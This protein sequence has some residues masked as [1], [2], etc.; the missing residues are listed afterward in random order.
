M[1]PRDQGR[2]LRQ[3]LV[4]LAFGGAIFALFVLLGLLSSDNAASK[5][6]TPN[7]S[8]R[9]SGLPVTH[10]PSPGFSLR[11]NLATLVISKIDPPPR[12]RFRLATLGDIRG[13][14]HDVSAGAA[15]RSSTNASRL[16]SG[17]K[18]NRAS[19]LCRRP[20][21]AL[22]NNT[23]G[24]RYCV[25]QAFLL[26]PG[27]GDHARAGEVGHVEPQGPQ[28]AKYSRSLSEPL[29]SGSGRESRSSVPGKA[30]NTRRK[31]VFIVLALAF[32]GVSAMTAGFWRHL[33][34]AYACVDPVLHGV[35]SNEQTSAGTSGETVQP[36]SPWAAAWR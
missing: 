26:T 34:R 17:F 31:A 35:K 36:S 33:S 25:R 5:A 18:A 20:E 24:D 12:Q 6:F 29:A 16:L 32:A 3:A 23:P 10:G 30:E 11:D 19:K 15:D 28:S 14:F 9:F 7:V 21:A 2:F 8:L 27:R 13:L 4:D 1:E 22:R